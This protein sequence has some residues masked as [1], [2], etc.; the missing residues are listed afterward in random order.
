MVGLGDLHGGAFGSGASAVSADGSVIVGG[1]TSAAGTEAFRWTSGGGM[2]GLGDLEGTDPEEEVFASGASGVSA[3]G[4]VIVGNS[5]VGEETVAFIWDP[6]HGMRDLRDVLVND[7]GLDLTGWT[8][9]EATGISADGNVIVGN[10]N[11][12]AWLAVLPEPSFGVLLVTGL[13]GLF[14]ARR[15]RE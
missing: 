9:D 13:L 7:Y 4:S 2:V 10:G 15:R 5:R 12:G 8:L 11:G 14:L 6:V 1:A 3:D